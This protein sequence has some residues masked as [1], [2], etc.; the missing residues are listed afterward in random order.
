LPAAELATEGAFSAR[1]LDL[2]RGVI[3]RLIPADDFPSATG[4]GAETYVVR[5]LRGDAAPQREAIR[6]GLVALDR[7]GFL[8][9]DAADQD[10]LLRRVEDEDWFRS[11]VELTAEGVYADP[12]NG[13]NTGAASWA[14]L[15]YDPRLPDGPTGPPPQG[16]PPAGV[17][18]PQGTAD[19]DVIIVGSGAGGG[20]AAGVLAAAG[21]RVLVLER[22]RWRDYVN[23]GH[24]DHLRNH[25]LF[26]HGH[27]TGPELAGNP[28][29]FVDPLGHEHQVA[30]HQPGYQPLASAVGGGTLVYGAQAWRFHPLD[31]R[32]AST[33]GVPDGS[34]LADWPL[35][36]DELAPW[37]DRAEWEIGVAGTAGG[38]PNGGPRTR[39]F[40]MPPLPP[41]GS[42]DVLRRGADKLELKTIAVPL[43]LNSVPRDGRPACIQCGSCIGFPCPVDAKNGTQN[44]ALKRAL[45]SGNCTL[46]TGV[47]A[48]RIAT[49]DGG[50]VIGVDVI[51]DDG[52]R[53]RLRSRAVIVAAAAIETARLL[54]ASRTGREPNGL[55]NNSDHLG[56]HLQ[57]HYYPGALGLFDEVVGSS[58][59]PGPS[60]ATTDYNHGN[61]SIVGGGMLAD[62]FVFTPMM[63]WQAQWPAGVPRWG[64]AAKAWMRANFHHVTQ[65]RGPVQEIPS[66]QARVELSREVRDS[67]GRPVARISGTT[68]GE[69][70]RT[71][72]FMRA[73]AED[74]LRAAGARQIWSREPVL[75]LSAHQHQAGTA[76]MSATAE[77]GVT[78]K[79]GRVWGHDN[80]FVADGALHVT[81]GGY[82]PVLTIVALGMRVGQAVA[83]SV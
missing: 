21:K 81:N 15:G 49:D 64:E 7:Q 14:M 28:R 13:G 54:L 38:D 43:A 48:E 8:A 36:Y 76:R 5:M 3:D 30:P 24:R 51:H 55:G 62:D 10:A 41:S 52:R 34:S 53:E 63:F 9:A 23:S 2:L 39:D 75:A 40:P 1:E 67:R 73:R 80:L 65:V 58:L 46:I 31:F 68:H 77:T 59:G 27:N 35:D 61:P 18:G 50:K 4:F 45:D 20:S 12:D 22:G 25:R 71:A 78:D 11:L 32:M 26:Q 57:G 17:C 6:A 83:E 70:V 33:Y 69:T 66:P 44:T 29:V 79:W 56:R 19:W 37:Y 47:V 16:D 74:W 72:Q 60:I 82:N 42:H